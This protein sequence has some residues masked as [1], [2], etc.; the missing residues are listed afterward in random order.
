[1]SNYGLVIIGCAVLCGY[2]EN[3]ELYVCML[4]LDDVEI[5]FPAVECFLYGGINCLRATGIGLSF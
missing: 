4:E 3:F 5:V 1:M 2:F